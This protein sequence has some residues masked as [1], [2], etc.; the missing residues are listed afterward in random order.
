MSE[1][2]REYIAPNHPREVARRKR[3][4]SAGLLKVANGL[5]LP[6]KRKVVRRRK[7]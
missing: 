5:V 1:Q 4:I 3:Q 2:E 6:P 7:S